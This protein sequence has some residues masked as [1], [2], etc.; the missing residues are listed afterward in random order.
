MLFRSDPIYLDCHI[1]IKFAFEE[2]RQASQQWY[3]D[4][5]VQVQEVHREIDPA[6]QPGKEYYH[7]LNASEDLKQAA[8]ALALPT[9]LP[10]DAVRTRE[11][12]DMKAFVESLDRDIDKLENE[13]LK[14][15]SRVNNV[16]WPFWAN[17]KPSLK[18]LVKMNYKIA[19]DA[20]E[21]KKIVANSYRE[22][23]IPLAES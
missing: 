17:I 1:T 16:S 22:W 23:A 14:E 15:M 21:A 10:H 7:H 19:K 20:L 4:Y 6:R 12:R 8:K 18:N 9:A 2:R 5:Q 11:V 3:E 13:L